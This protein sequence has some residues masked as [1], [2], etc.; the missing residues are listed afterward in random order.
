[1]YSAG[2]KQ[3]CGNQLNVL[4]GIIQMPQRVRQLWYS[5]FRLL[6]NLYCLKIFISIWVLFLQLEGSNTRWHLC[7][8]HKASGP[9][10]QYEYLYRSAFM[11]YKYK[12]MYKCINIHILLYTYVCEC[13]LYIYVPLQ[14]LNMVAIEHRLWILTT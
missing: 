4:S 10:N 14:N 1:M 8:N 3:H 11:W 6:L 2:W 13:T 12:C 5:E 9:L 7:Y